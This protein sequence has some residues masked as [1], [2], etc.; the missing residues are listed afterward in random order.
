MRR[1]SPYATW[2]LCTALV[3]GPDD[4]PP[5]AL[6]LLIPRRN[7]TMLD[8]WGAAKGTMLGLNSSGSN[9]FVVQDVFVPDAFAQPLD[10]VQ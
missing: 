8:D 7:L 6:A 4:D 5:D 1:G 9:S 3:I 10:V 2:A